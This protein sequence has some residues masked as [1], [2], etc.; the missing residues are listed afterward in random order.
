MY[1]KCALHSR[2]FRETPELPHIPPQ[3]TPG[4]LSASVQR[5]FD[6]LFYSPV[7]DINHRCPLAQGS[8]STKY[9]KGTQRLLIP[10]HPANPASQPF[11]KMSEQ[12]VYKGACVGHSGPVTSVATT[13]ENPDM[14]LTGS[15]GQ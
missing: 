15:R 8:S 4:F 12:I 13:S 10:L 1:Y 6:L 2:F 3:I 5:G 7:V 11:F 9:P 14:I